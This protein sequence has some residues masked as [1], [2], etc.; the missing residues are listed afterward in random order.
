MHA[1]GSLALWIIQ[2][3]GWQVKAA[4]EYSDGDKHESML[5]WVAKPGKVVIRVVY[6][7]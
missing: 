6:V 3:P 4:N 5:A 2:P 1:A 7:D